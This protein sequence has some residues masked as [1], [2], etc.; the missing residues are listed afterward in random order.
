MNGMVRNHPQPGIPQTS[1]DKSRRN[2]KLIADPMLDGH[3]KEKVYRFEGVN[4]YVSI[5]FGIKSYFLPPGSL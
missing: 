3:S 5:L 2:Y 4:P 1:A